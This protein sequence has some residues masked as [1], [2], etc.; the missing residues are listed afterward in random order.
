[1]KKELIC[2]T[3]V[4]IILLFTVGVAEADY[5]KSNPIDRAFAKDFE[6]A[7]NTAEINYVAEAYLNAWKAEL[8]NVGMLIKKSYKFKEDR[9]RVDAFIAS[10]RRLGRVAFDLEMLNWLDT[11]MPPAERSF[12][13]G[14]PGAALGAE[15]RIY[16]QAALHLISHYATPDEGKKY[17]F[18]YSGKGAQLDKIRKQNQ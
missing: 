10:S 18:L 17:T 2:I 1:M 11:S 14:G 7:S 16:K 9:T 13:T 3:L 12:G 6:Q 15:A 4:G 5:E 8:A